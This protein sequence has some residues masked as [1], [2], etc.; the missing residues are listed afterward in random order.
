MGQRWKEQNFVN[1][2]I[3]QDVC[4][5]DIWIKIEVWQKCNDFWSMMNIFIEHEENDTMI[6]QFKNENVKN[7]G[8]TFVLFT[9]VKR[10]SR[11]FIDWLTEILTEF[12]FANWKESIVQQWQSRPQQNKLWQIVRRSFSRKLS[13]RS[14]LINEDVCFYSTFVLL[15]SNKFLHWKEV[16]HFVIEKNHLIE[17]RSSYRLPMLFKSSLQWF[18]ITKFEMETVFLQWTNRCHIRRSKSQRFYRWLVSFV[19]LRRHNKVEFA[20]YDNRLYRRMFSI[21]AI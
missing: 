17:D 20:K 6:E 12:F 18:V 15:Y 3:F 5:R 14:S 9:F 1:L 13:F 7:F 19:C 8:E 16:F 2:S 4:R 10:I 11:Q 21:G